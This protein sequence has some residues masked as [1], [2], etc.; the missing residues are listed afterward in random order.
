MLFIKVLYI[1]KFVSDAQVF[2]IINEKCMESLR[3]MQ[4]YKSVPFKSGSYSLFASLCG[5]SSVKATLLS[6]PL[7]LRFFR[8]IFCFLQILLL[9]QG[10]SSRLLTLS[11]YKTGLKLFPHFRLRMQKKVIIINKKIQF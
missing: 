3:L 6:L 7:S 5:S 9:R 1:E 10:R 11:R 2:I 4:K 8:S